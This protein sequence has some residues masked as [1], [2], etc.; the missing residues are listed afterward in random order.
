M[1]KHLANAGRIYHLQWCRQAFAPAL[2]GLRGKSYER[3]LAQF[4]TAT[5]IYVWKL[6]RR[7]RGLSRPQT[8]L[9]IRELIEPLMKAPS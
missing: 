5:D 9:A 1:L 2:D 3:R 4:V 7:D 6:L 8:R